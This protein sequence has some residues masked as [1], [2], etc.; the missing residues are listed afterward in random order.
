MIKKNDPG[1]ENTFSVTLTRY[2]I[3]LA[4]RTNL[5]PF[6]QKWDDINYYTFYLRGWKTFIKVDKRHPP[7]IMKDFMMKP[8]QPLI[9][10]YLPF[11]KSTEIGQMREMARLYKSRINQKRI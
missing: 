8:N 7:E 9:V 10:L 3:D 6:K 4:S 11:R 2:D 5:Y 1:D